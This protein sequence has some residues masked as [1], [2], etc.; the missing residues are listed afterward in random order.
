MGIGGILDV[1]RAKRFITFYPN[2]FTLADRL[3]VRVSDGELADG[4]KKAK[5]EYQSPGRI[6]EL[7][8]PYVERSFHML[9]SA[10]HWDDA[11][12]ELVIY[13]DSETDAPWL[14]SECLQNY[15]FGALLEYDFFSEGHAED[16]IKEG[17]RMA[18]RV[19][20]LR[21]FRKGTRSLGVLLPDYANR[22]LSVTYLRSPL[23]SR[24]A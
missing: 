10:P 23:L 5:V 4:T 1:R 9:S 21:F 16:A 6:G 2:G 20:G 19:P 11:I 12:D 8:L 24:A 3:Q 14:F 22:Q 13:A 18:E 7:F 17:L 15:C